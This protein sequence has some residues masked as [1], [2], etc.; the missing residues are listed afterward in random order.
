MLFKHRRSV[1][2]TRRTN[3][4]LTNKAGRG[5]KVTR[6]ACIKDTASNDIIEVFLK[7]N[8]D[9]RLQVQEVILDMAKNR[10]A[11]INNIVSCEI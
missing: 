1:F 8:I 2:V 9:K 4:F 7:L 6:I 3:T 10:E 5:K 11:A